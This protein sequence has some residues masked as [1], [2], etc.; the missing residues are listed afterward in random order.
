MPNPHQ[1]TR[2]VACCIITAWAS[3]LCVHLADALEDA[4]QDGPEPIDALVT[5]ALGTPVEQPVSLS[6]TPPTP[7]I[8]PGWSIVTPPAVPGLPT[9]LGASTNPTTQIAV[10]PPPRAEPPLFQLFSIYRL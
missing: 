10:G 4:Q 7:P 5:Q 6:E 9:W 2:T 1:I 8:P 3:L